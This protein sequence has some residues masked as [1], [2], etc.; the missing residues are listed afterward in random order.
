MSSKV[1]AAFVPTF[2]KT[3]NRTTN[4][5]HPSQMSDHINQPPQFKKKKKKKRKEKEKET[6]VCPEKRKKNHLK[7]P[8]YNYFLNE[9]KTNEC[10]IER[11]L[12]L[13]GYSRLR[14]TP[15]FSADN[16]GANSPDVN[17]SP[18]RGR[19]MSV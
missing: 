13:A 8:K 1:S 3:N 16:F 14:Q 12:L 11:L 17:V 7:M 2:S 6:M 15:L 5:I 18:Q 9:S 10:P 19:N 4:K